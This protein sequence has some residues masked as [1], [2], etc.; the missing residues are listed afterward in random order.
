MSEFLTIKT[1]PTVQLDSSSLNPFQNF[2]GTQLILTEKIRLKDISVDPNI[3][4]PLSGYENQDVTKGSMKSIRKN[5]REFQSAIGFGIL[6]Q[7]TQ[8]AWQDC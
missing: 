4:I 3:Q 1:N 7:L 5:L 8:L 2:D 6:P